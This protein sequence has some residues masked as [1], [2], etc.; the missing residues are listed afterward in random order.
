MTKE[1]EHGDVVNST[2]CGR[3]EYEWHDDAEQWYRSYGVEL[4]EFNEA[5]L[6]RRRIASINDSP[7]QGSERLAAS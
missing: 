1:T 5:G 3:K 6:M 4:W 7:I 2:F